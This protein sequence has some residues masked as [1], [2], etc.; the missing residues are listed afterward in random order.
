MI[1]ITFSLVVCCRVVCNEQFNNS[2]SII[3][4]FVKYF[5]NVI[6]NYDFVSFIQHNPSKVLSFSLHYVSVVLIEVFESLSSLNS[7]LSP[8]LDLILIYFWGAV[9]M[10]FPYVYI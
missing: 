4:A 8:G 10:M 7:A 1:T 2:N 6:E 3:N 5:L 9:N